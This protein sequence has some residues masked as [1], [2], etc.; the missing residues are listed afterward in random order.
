M[1]KMAYNNGMEDANLPKI[2]VVGV[3]GAGC[4]VITAFHG[5]LCNM[6]TIA[7]NT[8]KAA[9]HERTRADEKIYICKEVLK[10]EGAKGDAS[11]GKTCAD[12]HIDEIKNAVAGCD[13]VFVIAGLG[14]GTGTGA[15][16]VVIDAAQSQGIRTFAVVIEPFAFEGRDNVAKSGVQHIR[17]VCPHVQIVSNEKVLEV[18]PDLTMNAAFAAVNLSILRHVTK[19][20]GTVEDSFV[21]MM[22]RPGSDGKTPREYPIGQ[23]SAVES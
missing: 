3:G 18:M 5:A 16:P 15:A 2:A 13:F 21:Q 10:G 4:N 1:L 11:L 20:A 7:I 6:K 8:D 12:I 19:L 9:L 22:A 14:G 23:L 17:A